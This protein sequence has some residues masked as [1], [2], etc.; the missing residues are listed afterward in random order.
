MSTETTSRYDLANRLLDEAFAGKGYA[1]GDYPTFFETGEGR[2]MPISTEV[3]EVE[4]LSGFLV[5]H[6]GRHFAFWFQ[7]DEEKGTPAITLWE[8]R[9]PNPRWFL[10]EEYT[11]AR[12]V[13]GLPI[14][15]T[16]DENQRAAHR[17]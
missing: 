13:V 16:R 15:T 12:K 17:S 6:Q 1:S 7:W 4:E 5:D 14:P 3:Q 9:E 10:S 8:P 11:D 2:F